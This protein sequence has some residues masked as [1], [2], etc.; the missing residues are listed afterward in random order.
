MDESQDISRNTWRK[1]I[2]GNNYQQ[3]ID[4]TGE[5]YK[6]NNEMKYKFNGIN[7]KSINYKSP[8]I[9]NTDRSHTNKNNNLKIGKVYKKANNSNLFNDYSDSD[10]SEEDNNY[11][12][13]A[14]NAGHFK[15]KGG[16]KL[17][18]KEQ[19]KKSIREK[20]EN[21]RRRKKI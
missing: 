8:D 13:N 12:N 7:F 11:Y 2:K 4:I 1:K 3:K 21:E 18:G 14:N 19:L 17:T 9:I 5:L 20:E 10:E 16:K 6:R 15:R